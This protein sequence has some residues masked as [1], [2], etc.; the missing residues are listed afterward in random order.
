M[1]DGSVD[2]TDIDLDGE[3]NILTRH[4]LAGTYFGAQAMID[5]L[6]NQMARAVVVSEY[7]VLREI[8]QKEFDEIILAKQEGLYEILNEQGH[9]RLY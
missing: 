5:S 8:N 4:R 2:I 3:E 7:C 6:K 1:I 9:K